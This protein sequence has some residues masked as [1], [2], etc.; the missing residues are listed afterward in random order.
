[1]GPAISAD[2]IPSFHIQSYTIFNDASLW[3]VWRTP[4]PK[5]IVITI[6]IVAL[7]TNLHFKNGGTNLSCTNLSFARKVY[8]KLT[9]FHNRE[10]IGKSQWLTDC[11]IV[12]I[13][14]QSL[15]LPFY[16]VHFQLIPIPLLRTQEEKIYNKENSKSVYWKSV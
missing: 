5:P 8:L 10:K 4:T 9:S 7:E 2:K 15:L 3:D 1:M 16:M 12:I 13:I 11:S 6:I 14:T